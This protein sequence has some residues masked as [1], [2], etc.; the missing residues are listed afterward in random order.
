MELLRVDLHLHTTASDGTWTPE[1]LVTAAQKAGL[2]IIS[3]TDHESV[4]N[5]LETEKL[6]RGAGIKFYRGVEISTTYGN[7][8]YHVLGYGIDIANKKLLS[9]LDYN[10]Y[11]LEKKDED[12]ISVL[13]NKG[14]PIT[15]DDYQ[16]Y[17]YDRCRG[18]FKALLYLQDRGFCTG[19]DDFFRHIFT[20]GNGLY[21]PEF[22]SI[23]ETIDIIHNAGGK[24]FLA[25][26]ASDFHGP[27]LDITLGVLG[28]E[29]FD[30]FEC[31]HSGHSLEDTA[32]LVRYC[33]EHNKL[34]SGGS[35]CHGTF[36]PGRIIGRPEIY[37]CDIRME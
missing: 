2:G 14:W 35:D 7:H 36:V 17:T 29:K 25:H 5:V 19:V 11:L 28:K 12:S 3:V 6:C 33:H 34:I 31:Y 8:C 16:N 30:G 1:A 13:I 4:A 27:G 18:G 32:S 26:S 21:F 9:L 37:E 22:N 24:A 23:S 20:T 15:I 10:T